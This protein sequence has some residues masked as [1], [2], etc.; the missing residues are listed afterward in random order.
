[1]TIDVSVSVN[2]R[3]LISINV[4]DQTFRAEVFIRSSWVSV[5]AC[6]DTS[7]SHSIGTARWR[8]RF[9]QRAVLM[10]RCQTSG[11]IEHTSTHTHELRKIHSQAVSECGHTQTAKE[12]IRRLWA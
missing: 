7:F 2:I 11:E 3:Q 8:Q 9:C 10:P 12:F 1:M 5:G 4:E 6:P